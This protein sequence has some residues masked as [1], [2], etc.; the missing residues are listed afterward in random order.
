VVLAGTAVGVLLLPVGE[1][2]AA[3]GTVELFVL[4]VGQGDAVLIRSPG[5]RWVLVDA[6]PPSG[7]RSAGEPAVLGQ[8]HRRG[9][10]RLEA[11]LLTHPHLDHIGGATAL[12]GDLPV[13]VVIDPGMP[14]GSGAFVDVLEA[15]GGVGSG[16]R[17]ARAGDLYPLDGAG[18]RVLSSLDGSRAPGP[19]GDEVNE[20]SL[21]VEL[22]FGA[23][24][25]L[26][27]GDAPVEVEEA[28]VRPSGP[29]DVLKVGHHGSRTSTTDDFLRQIRP[30]AAVISVG[31]G[32]RYGHPHQ[33]VLDAL[34]AERIPLFRTDRNG[35]V[36]IRARA[37]GSYRV[38]PER[39]P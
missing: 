14:R 37:D 11:M 16:W 26:L 33:S 35:T 8:L 38:T 15:A 22:E 2:I 27:T 23:F 5:A 12:L 25:A 30:G 36:R 17:A 1:R 6:G 32:N 31:Q 3:R 19:A 9:V 24:S 34:S 39:E 4:D 20:N 18:L 28:A 29:V 13:G 10:Q 21:V 7:F